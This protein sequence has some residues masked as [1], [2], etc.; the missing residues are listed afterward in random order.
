MVHYALPY[1]AKS[2]LHPS[3]AEDIL[4]FKLR[5]DL[6]KVACRGSVPAMGMEERSP[7]SQAGFVIPI[8]LSGTEQAASPKGQ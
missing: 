4:V 5:D 3:Q 1:L 7:R 6:S 2:T 8:N